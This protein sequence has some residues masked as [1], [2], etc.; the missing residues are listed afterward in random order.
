MKP[1]KYFV[2]SLFGL[3][4]TGFMSS[5]D[6]DL[7]DG[8]APRLFRPVASLETNNNS[9]IASW[10]NIAGATSYT[11]ELYKVTGTNDAGDNIYGM[12]NTR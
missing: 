9:I 4:M 1:L 2:I 3:L 12:K 10:D 6:D 7:K 11:L 5:C 8:D